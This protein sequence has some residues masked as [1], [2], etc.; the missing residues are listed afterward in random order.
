MRVA[1]LAD[2]HAN[3]HAL[4][5]VLA[6]VEVARVDRVI[7]LGDLVG[8]NA[9]PAVC[10]ERLRATCDVVV[11]GN[12]DRDVVLGQPLQG[13]SVTA[14]EVQAWTR[15]ALGEEH[16]AYLAGL[17]S[18][19]VDASGLVAAHGCYLSETY[20]SG[21]VT[22]TM[23]EA[24]LR[25]IAAR[26]AWPRPT[27]ALCGHTHAPMCAWLTAHGVDEGRLAATTRW[28]RDVKAVLIN[29]G[30]VGQPRDGDPRAAFAIVDV[31]ARTVEPMRVAYDVAGASA[32]V[33]QAGLPASLAARLL[34]GR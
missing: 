13:T 21:Y 14:R 19:V 26:T 8:Y 27:I 31:E 9:E 3:A 33:Q 10:V 23:V 2:V 34:E 24:N 22:S 15:K 29:P 28:P 18:H 30:S 16:L 20:V 7:C 5:A 1:L 32:R 17:P 12:H 4:E 11:A 25:A 6:A